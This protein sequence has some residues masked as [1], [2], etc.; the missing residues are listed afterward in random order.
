[1]RILAVSNLY[2]P[3]HIGGYEL[4][5]HD[6]L[7][8][9]K[10]SGHEVRVLTSTYGC[11]EP[12]VEDGVHRSL[13]LVF[14]R[15]PPAALTVEK[16]FVNQS[17]FNRLCVDFR[18]DLVFMWNLTN[19]SISLAEL[20]SRQGIPTCYYISDHWLATWEMDHWYQHQRKSSQRWNREQLVRAGLIPPP[21][22]L[23]L[24][25]TIFASK[26][27]M[28]RVE[29]V[30]KDVSGARIIH[31]GVDTTLFKARSSPRQYPNRLLYVGQVVPQKGVHTAIEALAELKRVHRT[32]RYELTVV[33]DCTVSPIYV[34]QLH[35]HAASLGVSRQVVFE[36]RIARNRL[37]DIYLDHD[38]LL[39]PSVWD[40]P[41]AITPLEAMSTSMAIVGTTT[42]GSSEIFEHERNC[43]V[44]GRENGLDC[45]EQVARLTREPALFN[46]ICEGARDTIERKFTIEGMVNQ[47]NATLKASAALR[48][49][50]FVP[51]PIRSGEAPDSSAVSLGPPLRPFESRSSLPRRAVIRLLSSNFF[52]RCLSGQRRTAILASAETRSRVLVLQLGDMTEVILSGPFLRELRNLCPVANI[53]LVVQPD[54]AHL[55]ELCPYVDEVK[56][57]DWRTTS[58]WQSATVANLVRWTATCARARRTA[59]SEPYDLAVSLRSHADTGQIVSVLYM[60]F[61]KTRR[62]VGYRHT[63]NDKTPREMLI[64]RIL[65]GGPTSGVPMHEV[66]RQFN[67]LRYLGSEPVRTELELWT[68]SADDHGA[69]ESLKNVHLTNQRPLIALGPG[70][71]WVEGRWST[72]KFIKLGRWLEEHYEA[73]IAIVGDAFERELANEIQKALPPGCAVALAG[74]MNLRQAGALLR[75][76]VLFV[77]N[78]SGF[79]HLA[80]AAGVPVVSI[81]GPGEYDSVRPWCERRSDVRLGL[82]CSPCFGN[83]M[84]DRPYCVDGIS[85]DDVTT[86]IVAVLAMPKQPVGAQLGPT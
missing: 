38:I 25:H 17:A 64:D 35:R 8:H 2:P 78:D 27:L 57:L 68:D 36:G 22:D 69:S 49:P 41:F 59:R 29:R 43:M 45:A 82:Q 44:F 12:R 28:D 4:G 20:A 53:T 75:K 32:V 86:A 9:L 23:D 79:M 74:K 54:L 42:G 39:F 58:D 31:W 48:M 13:R 77:G 33:G 10:A 3:L 26:H 55:V 11:A 62:R 6:V 5:C 81:F 47:I 84:F 85:V 30:G 50:L 56:T 52:K 80:A 65:T 34:S 40:E 76:C 14:E 24:R 71:A 15:V 37:P 66:Q 72:S 61:S 21:R 83:C 18:P 51:E 60:M 19:I 73:C 67:I 7:Q 63:P 16:E 70:A 46:A 1:M